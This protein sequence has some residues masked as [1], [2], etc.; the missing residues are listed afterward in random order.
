MPKVG[1]HISA[2][3]SLDLSIDRAGKI[4]AECT[5]IFIS[6]PQQWVQTK[7]S[8]EEIKIYRQKVD[9][10]NIGPNFIH[11]TYLINLATQNPDHLKKSMNWLTYALNTAGE[12]GIEG[13]IF[14]TGSHGGV[15]FDKV[16]DQIVRSIS[17]ILSEVEGS[18]SLILENSAGQGG[19]VGSKFSELGQIHSQ[20]A[21]DR[22]KVCLDTCHLFVAGFD[23][24]TKEGLQ[25]TLDE[26][27]LQV[28]LKN[29]AAIHANDT[30][31][32]LSSGKDR[33]ENIGEGF[34]GK[35]GFKNIINHPKLKDIPFILEVPGFSN[36][37]P[38]KENIDILKKLLHTG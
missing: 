34:L 23:I 8:A 11:G 15:G 2:A 20:V 9:K 12:L 30:K 7:H 5:Q 13:V 29:L 10:S 22:L 36:S 1:A 18:P 14:H 24:K 35:E 32:D 33:H 21:D 16:A 19:T 4:G 25:K 6:P 27:D 37:G 28:G 31:F 26:F 3:I 17:A 38:D